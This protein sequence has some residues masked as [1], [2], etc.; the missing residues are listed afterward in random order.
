MV[1]STDISRCRRRSTARSLRLIRKRDSTISMCVANT[2]PF[3]SGRGALMSEGGGGTRRQLFVLTPDEK[4]ATACVLGAFLLGLAT[5]HYRAD[6]PRKVPD[7]EAN[8]QVE[9]ASGAGNRATSP[10]AVGAQSPR[11]ARAVAKHVE[12]EQD[13]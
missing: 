1:E 7:P 12:A 9:M 2:D 6:H 11:P 13:D 4:R 8:R 3:T 5:M 10:K